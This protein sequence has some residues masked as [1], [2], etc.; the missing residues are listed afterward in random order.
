MLNYQRVDIPCS[1]ITTFPP[2]ITFSTPK[3]TG[4]LAHDV[5]MFNKK[6]TLRGI[7]SEQCEINPSIIPLNPGW[8]IGI[9]LLDYCNP[10]YIYI[11]I[12]III[13]IYLL[14][15]IIPYHQPTKVLNTAQVEFTPK[16]LD[17]SGPKP[18][19]TVE[20]TVFLLSEG[21]EKTQGVSYDFSSTSMVYVRFWPR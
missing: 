3:K 1:F 17:I 12:Y 6:W 16:A 14:G 5:I 9:P 10:Q 4:P 7:P 2:K 19:A 21:C 18:Q 20:S 8:F 13:Y 15:S 11:C